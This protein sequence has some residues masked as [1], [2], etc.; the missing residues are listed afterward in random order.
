MNDQDKSLETARSAQPE[1][2]RFQISL[3]D[4]KPSRAKRDAPYDEERL[5]KLDL[6]TF[7]SWVAMQSL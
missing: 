7:S 4:I 2:L 6:S 1:R 5:P 3:G